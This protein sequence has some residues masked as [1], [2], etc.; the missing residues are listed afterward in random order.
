MARSQTYRAFVARPSHI[1]DFNGEVLD[2]ERIMSELASEVRNLSAYATYVVRNDEV[3][4]AELSHVT[5]TA[6]AEAGRQAGVAMPDFLVPDKKDEDGNP[7]TD[8][9]GEPMV[10]AQ[11]APSVN[12]IWV[13][14]VEGRI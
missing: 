11:I 6:P 4:G 1:L 2:A 8:K 5:A 14:R 13:T 7:L 9:S 10:C 3:L 12:V